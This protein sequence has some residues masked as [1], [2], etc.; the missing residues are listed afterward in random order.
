MSD[1]LEALRFELGIFI[2][3]VSANNAS[4][5]DKPIP[6][7]PSLLISI[8]ISLLIEP[9][10]TISTI[11]M[12]SLSVT[13]KP[14]IKLLSTPSLSSISFI[15]GPPPWTTTGLI[16]TCFRSTIS[17]AKLELRFFSPITAPP[18]LTV[19]FLPEYLCMNG[20]AFERIVA[21]FIKS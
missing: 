6:L 7:P 19:I 20:N 2:F 18:S 12:V 17:L 14:F 4:F 21:L 1:N 3:F 11:F 5:P 9:D 8:T 16:P 15:F 13:L 10:N